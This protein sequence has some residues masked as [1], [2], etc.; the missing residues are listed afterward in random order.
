MD[1]NILGTSGT[2]L[3]KFLWIASFDIGKKNFSFYIEEIETN[4]LRTL[5][6]LYKPHRFNPNG[7]CTP[8]FDTLLSNIYKNGKK[9]LLE[10]VDLTINCDPKSYLDPQ[11]FYNMTELL[12]TYVEYWTQ[13]DIIIIEKQMSFGKKHNT[14]ALKLG[15]HCWSYFSIKYPTLKIVEFP[16]Y[17]KTQIL[18]AIKDKKVTKGGKVTY[19]AVDKPARKK[20]CVN[21]ALTILEYRGDNETTTQITKAKK[22]DDLSDVIC[23]LQAFKYCY[24][25]DNFIE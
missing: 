21:T 24:F 18:G 15:Q 22:K 5:T 25:I 16:A 23:Q 19:K 10:N 4:K 7:T 17:Y 14:M 3:E 12:D 20:W 13:C 6:N 9:I 1:N 11:T 8:E 2:E